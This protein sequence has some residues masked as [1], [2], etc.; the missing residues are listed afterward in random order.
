M[1]ARLRDEGPFKRI[2]VQP[3]AGDAGKALGAALW[4]DINERQ[5]H[6]DSPRRQYYMD[7]A[8]LGPGYTKSEIEDFLR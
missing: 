2:W 8:F 4:V 3:A 5:G 1:N 6:S 7:Q